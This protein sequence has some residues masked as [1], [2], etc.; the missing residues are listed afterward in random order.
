L[1]IHVHTP[2]SPAIPNEVTPQIEQYL[3]GNKLQEL[4]S[5]VIRIN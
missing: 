3:N 2:Q 4:L 5:N 1:I